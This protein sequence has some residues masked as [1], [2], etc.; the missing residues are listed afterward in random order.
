MKQKHLLLMFVLIAGIGTYQSAAQNLVIK[1]KDG[2]ENEKPLA[3]LK[4]LTFPDGN[5]L[6]TYNSGTTD[7]YNLTTVSKLFFGTAITG[8]N[9][10]A[11]REG[12]IKMFVYPNP[13]NNLITIQNAPEGKLITKIY[14]M[15]GMLVFNEIVT[16]GNLSIDASSF[17]KGSYL[18]TVNGQAFK[19]IKL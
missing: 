16:P 17:A 13:A 15:D 2:S 14:R 10:Y 18:L 3:S 4:K 12:S 11:L 6:L 9:E 5:L 8:T 1:T 19:F 7:S